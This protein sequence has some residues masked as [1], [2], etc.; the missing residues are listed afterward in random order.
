MTRPPRGQPP[1]IKKCKGSLKGSGVYVRSKPTK[2]SKWV[3]TLWRGATFDI[4]QE[5]VKGREGHWTKI[6]FQGKRGPKE[7]YVF[8][9]YVKK[10]PCN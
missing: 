7:G 4:L 1:T 3:V 8:S 2:I 6:R 9:K 10:G 5:R